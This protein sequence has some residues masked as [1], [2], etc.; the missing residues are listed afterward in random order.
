M[1]NLTRIVGLVIGAISFIAR[2]DICFAEVKIPLGQTLP[3]RA[4]TPYQ[5]VSYKNKVATLLSGV[6]DDRNTSFG[7]LKSGMGT[8][9]LNYFDGQRWYKIPLVYR[10]ETGEAIPTYVT[11]IFYPLQFDPEGNLWMC[12]FGHFFKLVGNEFVPYGIPNDNS[13]L[14]IWESIEYQQIRFDSTGNIWLTVYVEYKTQRSSDG[15]KYV[16]EA[17][18]Y[19]IKYDGSKYK[20]VA[21]DSLGLRYGKVAGFTVTKDNKIIIYTHMPLW[22]ADKNDSRLMIFDDEKL[23]TAFILPTPNYL[24]S[25]SKYPG[26]PNVVQIYEDRQGNIWFALGYP[27][28]PTSGTG[29]AMETGLVKWDRQRNI[30]KAFTEKDGYP[31]M[32]P[33]IFYLYDF[34]NGIVEDKEGRK[35]IGGRRY[36]AI[37]DS[38]D[39][40]V[41]PDIND[42]LSNVIFYPSPYWGDSLRNPED[43]EK[44]RSFN[45]DSVFQYVY[46]LLKREVDK[47]P[48][49][50]T[51]VQALT[52]TEDGSIWFSLVLGVGRGILRYSPG[53]FSD[54]PEITNK[55]PIV[56][57]EIVSQSN[58]V[59]TINFNDEV[60]AFGISIFDISGRKVFSNDYIIPGSTETY[61]FELSSE[62]LAKG[63]YYIVISLKDKVVFKKI[64]V[65]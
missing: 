6:I 50:I 37:I 47:I 24:S 4:Y 33:G 17:G 63:T 22:R 44:Y 42:F 34:C 5:L 3:G 31:W 48:P 19:L 43:Y 7:D 53:G 65:V 49:H 36:I 39:A 23:D 32:L 9:S 28:Q 41:E 13:L 8:Y 59:F 60:D 30:W 14:P 46:Y 45:R 26:N 58:P 62:Y 11:P 27:Y 38:N 16:F 12:G 18:T 52:T 54:T 21:A 64:I 29:E 56:Y 10:N 1:S 40:I 57:P 51:A 35:W 25:K 61:N 15:I 55:E 2:L 20:I